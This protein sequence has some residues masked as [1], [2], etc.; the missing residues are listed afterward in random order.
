MFENKVNYYVFKKSNL[1]IS[2]KTENI[3][4]KILTKDKNINPI[5]FNKCGA[6]HLTC[7][8]INRKYIGQNGRHF[9]IGF[10]EHSWNFKHGNG[11]YKFAKQLLEINTSL[12]LWEIS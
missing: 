9:H 5:K 6:Y 12:D 8:D 4:E 2:F 1:N 10:Q 11:K 3:V 7:Q